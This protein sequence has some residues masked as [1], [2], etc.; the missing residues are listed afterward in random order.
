MNRKVYA[1][2]M[3]KIKHNA[4]NGVQSLVYEVPAF[5]GNCPYYSRA[6]CLDY[7]THK[8]KRNFEVQ[9]LGPYH[10]AIDWSNLQ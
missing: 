3:Q 9:Q 6:D 8:L 1:L 7:L 2:C 10:L 5:F 4:Y